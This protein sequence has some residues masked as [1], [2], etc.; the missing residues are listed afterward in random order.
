[1]FSLR[2]S[3]TARNQW[4]A[5]DEL[6]ALQN[7]A[8]L[9]IQLRIV[10]FTG[11]EFFGS[12]F[13]N[14]QFDIGEWENGLVYDPD[15]TIAPYFSSTAFPPHG[16]NWGHYANPTYDKLIAQEQST[17]DPA[18]R[19]AILQKMQLVMRDNPPAL[20]LYGQNTPSEYRNTLHNYKPGPFSY[21]LWNTQDWWK[22]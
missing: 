10:N 15:S 19:K 9:G 3:T 17:V 7:Y 4:R 6:I 8:D 1:M 11:S 22:S 5:Q 21:E 13:P 18:K 12:T 14:G 16:S 2:W 20:W